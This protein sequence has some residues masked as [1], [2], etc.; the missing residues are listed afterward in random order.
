MASFVIE[1]SYFLRSQ[2]YHYT[3][4]PSGFGALPQKYSSYSN[5]IISAFILISTVM[6]ESLIHLGFLYMKINNRNYFL[7]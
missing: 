1:S 7:L 2:V 5:I 3:Y 6:F 4:M